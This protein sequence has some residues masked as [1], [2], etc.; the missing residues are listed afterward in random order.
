MGKNGGDG[1]LS[2]EGVFIG[3][4]YGEVSGWAGKFFTK[5]SSLRL[6]WGIE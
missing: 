4:V 1:P 2:W 6:G 3:V 5:M